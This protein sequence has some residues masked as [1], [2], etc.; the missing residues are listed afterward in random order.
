MITDGTSGSIAD[1]FAL[2][3][4][5]NNGGWGDLGGAWLIVI[6]MAL[7]GWGN[8]GMGA[9]GGMMPWMMSQNGTNGDVQ[10]GF[11]QAAIMGQL[12]GIQSAIA[13]GNAAAEANAANRQI[14]GMQQDFNTLLS[15]TNQLNTIA[16]NQQQCCCDNRAAIADLK[17]AITQDGAM[18]RQ[19]LANGVQSVQ[20]KLC[21]LELDGY[22]QQL[23][24]AQNEVQ[25]LRFDRSQVAQSAQLMADNARQT[26]ALR[27]ALNPTPIPAYNV[28]N[29]YTGCGGCNGYNMYS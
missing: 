15:L 20:D 6:L 12:G 21:Q 7:F 26:E 10:R 25:A 29:P 9:G 11:D 19:A 4:G 27:Q 5:R 2:T 1:A 13:S 24:A 14:A 23:A 8:G 17:N 28:P 22:K 3:G 18:T 16:S